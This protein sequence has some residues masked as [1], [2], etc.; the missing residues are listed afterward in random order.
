[1]GEGRNSIWL[2]KQGWDV[3]GFDPAD[4]AVAIARK[5]A[6][7]LNLTLHAE[8]VRDHDYA[9]GEQRFDLIVFSWTM[10]LVPVERVAASLKPGG[11]VVMEC[12]ADFVGPNGMLKLFDPLRI[13]RYEIVRARSD[14]YN[15][16][17]TEVLRM[18]AVKP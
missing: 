11:R 17:E 8:A 6:A 2:A 18:I 4:A 12:G 13:E 7:A 14:F 9:F 1:M 15:R 3:W 5:R 16:R 10:P